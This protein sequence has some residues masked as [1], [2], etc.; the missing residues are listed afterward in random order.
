[1][2]L[3][4]A[5]RQQWILLWSVA[6][7]IFVTNNELQQCVQL[8]VANRSMWMFGVNNYCSAL[9]NQHTII[10]SGTLSSNRQQ[11][12]AHASTQVKWM[13]ARVNTEI[14]KQA[15][16]EQSGPGAWSP[17]DRQL[18]RLECSAEQRRSFLSQRRDTLSRGFA[19][20]R[21]VERGAGREA[22][23]RPA[24]N[25]IMNGP[26]ICREPNCRVWGVHF[27]CGALNRLLGTGHGSFLP[28]PTLFY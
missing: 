25:S 8:I 16:P 15:A 6:K 1:M 27:V 26:D 20:R 9:N 11:C 12:S 4:V 3:I 18:A 14:A 21:P 19:V 28:P 5:Y 24:V 10:V 17:R 7:M 23:V 2:N 22:F 13:K